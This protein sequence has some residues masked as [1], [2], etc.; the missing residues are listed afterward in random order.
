MFCEEAKEGHGA[1]SQ[2]CAQYFPV[3]F[4]VWDPR[5]I[6]CFLE[7]RC[8]ARE[9]NASKERM[10]QRR[11]VTG[12]FVLW[13]HFTPQSA[14][15]GEGLVHISLGALLGSDWLSSR[16]RGCLRLCISDSCVSL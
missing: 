10:S 9:R 3:A 2:P 1:A 14:G 12:S 16:L 7:G 4:S 11:G 13:K 15:S 6:C 5:S 8:G